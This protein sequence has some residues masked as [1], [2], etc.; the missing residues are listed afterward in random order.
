MSNFAPLLD[1][2]MSTVKCFECC[3][4]DKE[5]VIAYASVAGVTI[6]RL[7]E[8]KT[9]ITLSFPKIV[10]RLSVVKLLIHTLAIWM[11][12]KK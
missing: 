3:L 7:L 1:N 2:P 5:V 9:F 4:L 11:T 10:C 12:L 8:K 6:H